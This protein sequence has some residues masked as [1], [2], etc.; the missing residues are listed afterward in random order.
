MLNINTDIA[1]VYNR[2]RWDR[3][4]FDSI[5]YDHAQLLDYQHPA[6]QA[7]QDPDQEIDLLNDDSHLPPPPWIPPPPPTPPQRV[8]QQAG[9]QQISSKGIGSDYNYTSSATTTPL[10]LLN[11]AGYTD[12]E[13]KLFYPACSYQCA[14]RYPKKVYNPSCVCTNTRLLD[15]IGVCVKLECVHYGGDMEKFWRVMGRDC[16]RIALD[17]DRKSTPE[18]RELYR[19]AG[20]TPISSPTTVRSGSSPR[21]GTSWATSPSTPRLGSFFSSTPT[22]PKAGSP[23]GPTSPST[24]RPGTSWAA[25]PS[26]PRSGSSWASSPSTPRPG[27]SFTNSPTTPRPGTAFSLLSRDTSIGTLPEDIPL[28]IMVTKTWAVDIET[29]AERKAVGSNDYRNICD[30]SYCDPG[31]E[32]LGSSRS[33]STCTSD[34]S[35]S[36]K[37]LEKEEE[38]KKVVTT[39][40][41]EGDRERAKVTPLPAM[42]EESFNY[43]PSITSIPGMYSKESQLGVCIGMGGSINSG[44]SNDA[45]EFLKRFG[46]T[47]KKVAGA[48]KRVRNMFGRV[49]T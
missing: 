40:P 31:S 43:A 49:Q 45:V 19:N 12:G 27:T 37:P 13:N 46:M 18:L 21:P 41:V 7:H 22:T 47:P 3:T 8:Y 34:R 30:I 26:T 4:S 23:W 39:T 17:L 28:T 36:I 29:V 1:T 14:G 32:R 16:G 11:L 2:R 5:E 9:Q 24:P 48:V 10:R 35:A 6:P 42:P 44:N 33:A 25:S 20:H 15:E 38:E